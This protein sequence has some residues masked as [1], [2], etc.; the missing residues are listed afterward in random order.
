[1]TQLQHVWEDTDIFGGTILKMPLTWVSV[2][3]ALKTSYGEPGIFLCS[4]QH[5]LWLFTAA[6]IIWT[7]VNQKILPKESWKLLKPLWRIFKNNY[8]YYW[9]VTKGQGILFSF[10]L[11]SMKQTTYWKQNS[12]TSRKHILWIKMMTGSRAIWH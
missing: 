12:W 3:I 11:K 1:M 8:H 6:Q 10:R 5:C 7:K 2:M 4:R 9:Y